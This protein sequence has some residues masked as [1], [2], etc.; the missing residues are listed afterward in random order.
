MKQKTELLQVV[1]ENNIPT[2]VFR[3]RAEIHQ[4]GLWHRV[5]HL[6]IYNDK[7]QVLLQKRSYKKDL[8]PGLWSASVGG[9]LDPNETYSDAIVRE[10]KEEI[11]IK[12]DAKK[13]IEIAIFKLPS[14]DSHSEL[15]D[16]EFVKAFA[17]KLNQES[18]KFDEK[19]VEEVK[20]FEIDRIRIM[21]IDKEA[22]HVFTNELKKHYVFKVL[23]KIEKLKD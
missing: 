18:F 7:K 13:L 1:D 17:Y 10:A 23:E 19:E 15:I 20:W 2:K 6:W 4:E 22:K 8:F 3:K 5:S 11:G 9:H 12:I 14:K 16:N 21:I